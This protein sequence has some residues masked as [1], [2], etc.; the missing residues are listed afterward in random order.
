MKYTM[1]EPAPLR[2]RQG[3]CSE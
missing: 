1:R 2:W 3:S